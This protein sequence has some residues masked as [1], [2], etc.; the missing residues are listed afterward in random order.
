MA[1]CL[2]AGGGGS[3][4]LDVITADASHVLP[5]A[6]FVNSSGD[7]VPGTMTTSAA[8]AAAAV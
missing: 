5:A 3:D 2:L 6:T 1:D 8:A 7:L 4:N